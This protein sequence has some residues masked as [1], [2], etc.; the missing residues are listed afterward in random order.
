MVLQASSNG[1]VNW[2]CAVKISFAVNDGFVTIVGHEDSL[3]LPVAIHQ[4]VNSDTPKGF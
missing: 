1:I 3:P 4:G 2:F